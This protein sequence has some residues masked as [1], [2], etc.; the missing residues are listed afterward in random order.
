M[1]ELGAVDGGT[2]S[3][4]EAD[5]LLLDAVKKAA[6]PDELGGENAQRE[7]NGEGAGAGSE[8]HNDAENKECKSYEN[9][10]EP[11]G[12]LN[13]LNNHYRSHSPSQSL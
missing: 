12:L 10:N 7:D 6:S 9:F 3:C 1:A 4:T 8:H 2:E 5:A 11:L 13:C